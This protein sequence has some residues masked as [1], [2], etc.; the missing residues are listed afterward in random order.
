MKEERCGII[1]QHVFCQRCHTEDSCRLVDVFDPFLG[2]A[3]VRVGYGC[4]ITEIQLD[5]GPHRVTLKHN[6]AGLYSATDE[7]YVLTSLFHV[8]PP[9]PPKK[10]QTQSSS[11]HPERKTS[12]T[13]KAIG[14]YMVLHTE[15]RTV[16]GLMTL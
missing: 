9:S 2:P 14:N 13:V 3:Q 16:G 12:K 15:D 8:K 6:T 5:V 11:G 1:T 4:A 10:C 7:H